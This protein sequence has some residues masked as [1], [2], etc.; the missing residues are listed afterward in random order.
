[1]AL[2]TSTSALLGETMA[3]NAERVDEMMQ[4]YAHPVVGAVVRYM[5][6]MTKD[7]RQSL[8]VVASAFAGRHKDTTSSE[9]TM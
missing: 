7:E 2:G 3:E 1:M 5:C 8:R 6:D 9:R 4:I